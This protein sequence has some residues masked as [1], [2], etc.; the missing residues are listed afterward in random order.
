LG[1]LGLSSL[2]EPDVFTHFSMSMPNASSSPGFDAIHEVFGFVVAGLLNA[3]GSRSG[4][5][6]FRAQTN[7]MADQLLMALPQAKGLMLVRELDPWASSLC[8]TF[9]F[10]PE[11]VA[12][13][14]ASAY[15]G[16][17]ACNQMGRPLKI[18]HYEELC[19][20][21]VEVL[22]EIGGTL[23]LESSK[24]DEESVNRIMSED[25][26]GDS[27]LGREGKRDVEVPGGFLESFHHQWATRKA[28]MENEGVDF[29]F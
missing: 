13:T 7:T 10:S 14:L 24:V 25:S 15:R 16:A 3:A 19:E 28:D 6:K 11:T 29:L 1:V 21:P 2:S 18:V 17:H 23:G 8:R 5:L 27:P 4:A 26:Q 9:S 12:D 22:A 20:R